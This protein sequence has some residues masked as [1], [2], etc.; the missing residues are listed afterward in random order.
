VLCR[1]AASI[2]PFDRICRAATAMVAARYP[3]SRPADS[4]PPP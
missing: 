3:T 1:A 4:P 2:E